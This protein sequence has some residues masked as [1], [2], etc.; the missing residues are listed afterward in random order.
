M[1]FETTLVLDGIKY[2]FDP[3]LDITPYESV[4]FSQLF[5]SASHPHFNEKEIAEFLEKY[6]LFRHFVREL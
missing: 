4:R 3:I 5:Y 2:K 1:T 6:N